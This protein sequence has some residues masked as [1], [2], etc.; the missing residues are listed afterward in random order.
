LEK[1]ETIRAENIAA[2]NLGKEVK[3]MRMATT[4]ATAVT[5]WWG[6][7]SALTLLNIRRTWRAVQ[8]GERR[9]TFKH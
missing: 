2:G 5:A 6:K 4:I 3:L 1:L 8:F 9:F 7:R